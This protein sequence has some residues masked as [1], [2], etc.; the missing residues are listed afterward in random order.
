MEKMYEIKNQ[1][2]KLLGVK[3][4][5]KVNVSQEHALI[6]METLLDSDQK[7]IYTHGFYRLQTY[8]KQIKCGNYNT[9]PAINTVKNDTNVKL[10]DG[11]N[12]LG[13]V[14]S[15]I[16]MNQAI[17]ISE[18]KGVGVVGVR[19]SNHFGTAAYYAEL[20]SQKDQIGIVMTNASPAIAPT[21]GKTPLLGNN[22]WSISVPSS[23]GH[24]ITLDIA[25]SVS[26]RGKIRLKALNG[27][28]IP[29][30]WALDKEG[31]PTTNAH[32]AL[33]G[34]I[35]PIGDYKGYGITFMISILSGILTGANFDFDIPLIEEDGVRNNGHLFVSLNIS[36]FMEVPKFK[37][38]IGIFVKE[39]KNS[40]KVKDVD[41]I[42]LPGEM[43]WTKKLNQKEE[44][45]K[46]PER[47]FSFIQ[48]LS[49][50]YG[51]SLPDYRLLKTV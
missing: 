29:V 49:E 26:A 9:S 43:E 34:L 6:L 51:V 20:A 10:L 18:S 38:R 27:E 1:D 8:I 16:A 15:T 7:G 22:P 45:V 39:I 30:G 19:K 31:N 4:L 47:I 37:E 42:L 28:S 12:G 21:G 11:D 46:V 33:E 35:L 41:Q 25:N 50:Q 13:S 5:E 3:I 24:P 44:Y 48:S 17:N 32:E 23:L 36:N 14:V 40:P 2:Y